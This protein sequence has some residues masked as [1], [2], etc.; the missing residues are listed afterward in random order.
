MN[1]ANLDNTKGSS[2]DQQLFQD[3]TNWELDILALQ[4]VGVN[5]SV[6]PY[7]DQLQQR[8]DQW[9][10]PGSTKSFLSHNRHANT[11]NTGQWG[12][13]GIM[14][15]GKLRHYA[16]GAGSNKAKLGRWTWAKYRGKGG[17]VL[18]VVSIYRPCK[19]TSGAQTVWLQQKA[20]L[21]DNKDDRDPLVAWKE[22]FQ[23]KL[24]EW[25][26]EGDQLIVGGDVNESVS[27]YYRIHLRLP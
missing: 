20:A 3:I 12:G 19:N 16:M 10:E 11:N 4:E 24:E 18:R 27:R 22:D 15:R 25:I 5:W 13:T 14:T 2:K 17:I 26:Q 9:F 7:N 21:Q 8:L 23:S 6:V 1:I